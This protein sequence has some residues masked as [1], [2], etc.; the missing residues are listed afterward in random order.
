MTLRTLALMGVIMLVSAV[1]TLVQVH[2]TQDPIGV[3]TRWYD[4]TVE[5]KETFFENGKLQTRTTY[6]DDGKTIITHEEWDTQGRV[7]HTKFRLPDGKVEAKYFHRNK[8]QIHQ[9][10]SGDMSYFLMERNYS[11]NGNISTE[12]FFTEDGKVARE[13]RHF[14]DNGN[15]SFE[16]VILGNAD[17][18]V[19]E[20][21]EDGIPSNIRL[22]RG[23]GSTRIEKYRRNGYRSAEIEL[24]TNFGNGLIDVKV[25]DEKGVL[26]EHSSRPGDGTETYTRFKER[27]PEFKQAF[28]VDEHG[29]VNIRS[30]E[31]F[32]AGTDAPT[33]KVSQHENGGLKVEIFAEDGSLK[34]IQHVNG[35]VVLEQHDIGA[36]NVPVKI[37]PGEFKPIAQEVL[38]DQGTPLRRR[39]G[40]M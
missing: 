2:Y 26:T 24:F 40:V 22:L 16:H 8:L 3:T 12:T 25:F 38:E 31:L 39:Q 6:G 7:T 27:K 11:W 14:Y 34:S 20:F 30:V 18:R 5:L 17:Q 29:R 13:K 4:G 28:T 9:I 37:E 33:R 23:N 1:L 19:T 32:E 10:L 35:D 36:D 15:M 21:Y